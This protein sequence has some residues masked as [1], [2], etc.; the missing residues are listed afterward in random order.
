MAIPVRVCHRACLN[1]QGHHTVIKT[2]N[3]RIV[4]RKVMVVTLLSPYKFTD[5][6]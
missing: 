1:E 5:V 6:V 3:V 4:Q 2:V